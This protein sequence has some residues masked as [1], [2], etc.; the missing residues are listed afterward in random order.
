MFLIDFKYIELPE[1]TN[2]TIQKIRI[3][4]PLEFKVNRKDEI[5]K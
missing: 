3:I 4:I 5:I 1:I 2:I